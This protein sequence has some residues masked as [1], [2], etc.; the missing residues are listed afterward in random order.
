MQ[1]LLAALQRKIDQAYLDK[2]DCTIPEEFWRR[3]S[4]DWQQEQ[5]T[6][7][8][9]LEAL[10]GSPNVS[11]TLN[12]ARTL[13]LANKAYS[14]YLKQ[15]SAERAKLLRVVLSNCS[16][17]AANIYP[18]YRKPFDLIFRRSKTEEWRPQGDS[19]PRYRR[20]RA[21]S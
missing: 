20:E 11:W 9:G 3:N 6:P 18:T 1:Q 15:N 21:M 17:D 16:L 12:A 4:L 14:L 10:Q 8:T 7:L 5:Q 2:L 19:N 13:E